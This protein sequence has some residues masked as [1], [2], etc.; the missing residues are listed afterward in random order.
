MALPP[1]YRQTLPAATV[2]ALAFTLLYLAA[3]AK[4][5]RLAMDLQYDDVVYALDAARRL[6]T[7]R[8]QGLAAL[9]GTFLSAPP[10]S[11]VTT[12]QALAAFMV[13]GVRDVCLYASNA[14][15]LLALA[16]AVAF[17]FR[18]K[19]AAVLAL[20]LAFALTSPL[21]Y[22]AIAEF[23]PDVALG[24]VT[25]LMVACMLSAALDGRPRR[26]RAAGVLLGAALLLKPT[27]FAHTLFLAALLVALAWLGSRPGSPP[28]LARFAL[29]R[30]ERWAF[31]GIGLAIAAPYF[32]VNGADILAYFWSNTR[33]ERAIAWNLPEQLSPAQVVGQ[34]APLVFSLGRFHG[35]A[36]AILAAAFVLALRRRGAHAEASRI[37]ALLAFGAVSALVIVAGRHPSHFFFATL[38]WLL[39]FAVLYGLAS[40]A[41]DLDA[42]ARRGLVAW[43]GV[44][45]A[46]LAAA[47]ALWPAVPWPAGAYHGAS[48]NERIAAIVASNRAGVRI[49]QV[50]VATAGPVN[51]DTLQWVAR[52]AGEPLQAGNY[53]LLGDADEARRIAGRHDFVVIPRAGIAERDLPVVRLRAALIA[54]MES[55]SFVPLGSEGDDYRVFAN[56]RLVQA[57]GAAT[58]DK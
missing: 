15:I 6:D 12:L 45:V 43:G 1:D 21:A 13:G 35:V 44:L 30:R 23:R 57:A 27:F 40:C 36:A 42:G 52:L 49:P 26:A 50:F 34:F 28:L 46:A 25:A 2:A 53:H 3:C 14:W 9:A 38:Q 51:S 17:G 31:A 29:P 32:A 24:F 7:A 33:G 55:G 11:A 47:D 56:P 39:L 16:A 19:R 22:F 58:A 4:W 10:H 54:F 18:S 20:A 48:W 5:G 37:A 41:P 8:T